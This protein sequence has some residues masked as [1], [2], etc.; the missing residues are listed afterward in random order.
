MTFGQESFFP[1]PFHSL[2]ILKKY[3][4]CSQPNIHIVIIVLAALYSLVLG[5]NI[6][7]EYTASVFRV[8]VN[9]L[10]KMM[11]VN[12]QVESGL[13]KRRAVAPG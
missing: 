8:E 7:E 12:E 9:K 3:I 13:Q 10:R 4:I 5:T 11:G 1:C 6:S 2:D